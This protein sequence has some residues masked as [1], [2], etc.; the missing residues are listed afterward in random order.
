[1]G[2]IVSGVNVITEFEVPHSSNYSGYI[3]YMN[4]E[5]GKQ[6]EYRVYNDYL[7]KTD[8]LFTKDNDNLNEIDILELKELFETAQKNGSLLWKTV[9]SF[10]NRWLDQYGIYNMKKDV[11][12]L[13]LIHI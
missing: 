8:S 12:N 6:Q 1:M 11:L 3:D 5:Q 10:D 4:K 7:A 9:I 13:S 2:D